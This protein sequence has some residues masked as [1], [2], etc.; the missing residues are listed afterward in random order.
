MRKS[1]KLLANFLGA[2]K[3]LTSE[4][5]DLAE[6]TDNELNQIAFTVTQRE[7]RKA[8]ARMLAAKGVPTPTSAAAATSAR[9]S[10]VASL[11]VVL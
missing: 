10:W 6:I 2:T 11:R 9:C 1:A 8:T 5:I 3:E 4:Y 7:D